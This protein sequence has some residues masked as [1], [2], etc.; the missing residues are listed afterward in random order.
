MFIDCLL[1]H[2][3]YCF[4]GSITTLAVRGLKRLMER[5]G[6]GGGASS[7]EEERKEKEEDK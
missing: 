3:C 5:E 6:G 7:V 4:V 1:K 2:H